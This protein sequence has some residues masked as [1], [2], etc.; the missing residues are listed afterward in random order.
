MKRLFAVPGAVV[1]LLATLAFLA[2]MPV[3]SEDEK[4]KSET[5]GRYLI[6]DTARVKT[7]QK[8][9]A[10]AAAGGF[11]VVSGDAGYNILLLEKD[12][13]AKKHEYLFTDALFRAV[14]EDQVKGYR[15]LPFSFGAGRYSLGAVLEKLAEGETQAEYHVL[16]TMQTG[17]FQKDLNEWSGKGFRLVA[18]SGADRNYG[19]MERP[20]GAPASGPA[21][22][23][24]LLAT[25]RTGTMQ[26]EVVDTVARG[27]RIV[28]ATGAKKEM[29]I[30]LEKLASGDPK[31]E[32]RLLSTTRSGTLEREMIAASREGY[33]L[34][35]MTLCA[36]QKSVGMLGT[37]GYEVTAIMEKASSSVPVEY[38]MLS[39]KRVSTLEKELAEAETAGWSVNR[40]FL[41]YE[42]QVLILE[43]AAQ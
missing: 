14:K 13:T 21:D 42:E 20:S 5:A 19:L 12:T 41:S 16:D 36:L 33:R 25:S 24:V 38:K 30:V 3:Q 1:T 2:P 37:Y 27:Y 40:L 34:L 26:K 15:V 31:P 10:D 29:L 11:R 4:P 43:K 23:Y 17:N 39:T 28:A 18:L 6:L 7:L 35:P 32:Y 8:E 9:L 22:R